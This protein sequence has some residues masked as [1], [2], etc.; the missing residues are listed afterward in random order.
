MSRGARIII[1]SVA[2]LAG[3]VIVVCCAIFFK[4]GIDK[5]D[6]LSSIISCILGVLAVAFAI[7]SSVQA[8]SSWQSPRQPPQQV[9]RAGN[10][11][12]QFQAGG[13]MSIGDNNEFN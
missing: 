13:D 10:N 11:S 3:T 12:K 9:Q 6:K 2:A 4:I 8:W 7:F 5:A 1:W